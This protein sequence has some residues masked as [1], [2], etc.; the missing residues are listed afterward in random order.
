MAVAPPRDL[1]TVAATAAAVCDRYAPGAPA[2]VRADAAALLASI[3][4]QDPGSRTLASG[5]DTVVY[6][7]RQHQNAMR[8]SG[9]AGLLAPW[10]VRR[11]L[12]IQAVAE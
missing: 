7:P 10:R 11:A 12:P 2:G 9:A 5:G 3:L 8:V 1:S 4:R 6:E